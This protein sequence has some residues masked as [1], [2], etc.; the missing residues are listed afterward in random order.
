MN[1]TEP[2]E[3]YLD[4]LMPRTAARRAEEAKAAIGNFLAGQRKKLNPPP[5]KPQASLFPPTTN[6]IPR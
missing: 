4:R 5:R 2:L 3:A 6:L 1:T